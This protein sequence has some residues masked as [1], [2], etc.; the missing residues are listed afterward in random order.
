MELNSDRVE[1]EFELLIDTISNSLD[2]IELLMSQEVDPNA[3]KTTTNQLS[4]MNSKLFNLLNIHSFKKKKG[5]GLNTF[6][7]Q[8][9]SS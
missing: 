2:K 7:G 1:A 6:E 3:M 4:T 8:S 9:S 5:R